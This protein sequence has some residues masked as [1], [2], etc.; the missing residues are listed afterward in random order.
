MNGIF[1]AQPMV[2]GGCFNLLQ[3]LYRNSEEVAHSSKP[4]TFIS[5]DYFKESQATI[6]EHAGAHHLP[7]IGDTLKDL[8]NTL[9][10]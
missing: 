7:H 4:G 2:D 6:S 8:V 10:Q 5:L 9:L 3:L 1:S